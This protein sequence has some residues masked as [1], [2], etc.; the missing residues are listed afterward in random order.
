MCCTARDADEEWLFA[1]ILSGCIASDER[2]AW[3]LHIAPCTIA[4]RLQPTLADC[5]RAM[6]SFFD[7]RRS[8]RAE[9]GLEFGNGGRSVRKRGGSSVGFFVLGSCLG[10]D[11]LSVG[12]VVW[13]WWYG[14]KMMTW[15]EN[16]NGCIVICRWK[17]FEWG[18]V[19]LRRWRGF[20]VN[21]NDSV[22]LVSYDLLGKI[23]LNENFLILKMLIEKIFCEHLHVCNKQYCA[24]VTLCF[25]INYNFLYLVSR[26]L[27]NDCDT[28]VI[29]RFKI[30]NVFFP[31]NEHITKWIY[32]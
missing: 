18:I 5:R 1:L 10:M 21:G 20:C 23:I 13:K 4:D 7:D 19:L 14:M 27:S 2:A 31:N 17:C 22:F 6:V 16:W 24:L 30:R 15:Y 32:L 3:P 26:V 12:L 9:V 29:V 11:L 28:L 25:L 8:G